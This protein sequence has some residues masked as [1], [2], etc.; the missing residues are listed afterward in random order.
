[1]AR[2]FSFI[3]MFLFLASCGGSGGSSGSG[4]SASMDS[5]MTSTNVPVEAQTFEVNA[6][7]SGF[8]RAHEEKIYKAI[9]MIKKVIASDEFRRKVLNKKYNGK[10]QYV[11][12]GGL[13]N[14][15]IYQK[16]LAGSEML[17]PGNNNTMDIQLEAYTESANVIGYT[18]PNILTVYM[19]TRYLNKRSFGANQVA[20]NI[21]HEWLHKL[22][23]KHAYE[24][25]ANRSHSV[26]YAIGYIVRDLAA[27][28]R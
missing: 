5:E 11:D 15:Q 25:T 18:K 7:L 26:P 28:I 27:K 19:N 14:A 21:V 17:N 24:R 20:M 4:S 10:K 2:T 23:F 6:S 13:T 1:M 8:E 3:F 9:E 16:L 12:N 22:G